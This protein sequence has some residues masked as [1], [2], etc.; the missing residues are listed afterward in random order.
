MIKFILFIIAGFVWVGLCQDKSL[1]LSKT[2]LYIGLSVLA[3]LFY[4]NLLFGGDGW[5]TRIRNR[6]KLSTQEKEDLEFLRGYSSR[7]GCLNIYY[8]AWMTE[9][10]EVLR[11]QRLSSALEE[12][13]KLIDKFNEI[14]TSVSEGKG[15]ECFINM[16]ETRIS[17]IWAHEFG[18]S[19][20]NT[21]D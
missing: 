10:S 9:K 12:G 16:A 4:G 18:Q 19:A 5:V 3:F 21:L 20:L 2:V 15:S 6:D 13:R 11:G 14:K 8:R 7:I 1:P 17:I